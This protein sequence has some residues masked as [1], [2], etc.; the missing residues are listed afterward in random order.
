[1]FGRFHKDILTLAL[2]EEIDSCVLKTV[3]KL[4]T[5]AN[6]QELRSLT[7]KLV[8][9]LIDIVCKFEF[10]FGVLRH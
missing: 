10:V 2:N 1:M 8:F 5:A 6:L 9:I 4:Q 3:K 7:I